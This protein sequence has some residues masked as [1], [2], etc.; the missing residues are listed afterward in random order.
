MVDSQGRTLLT[1]LL[2][3][4]PATGTA[5]VHIT[6]R[7]EETA[8]ADHL[9]RLDHGRLVTADQ[10]VVAYAGAANPLPSVIPQPAP[11]IL[12]M[13]DPRSTPIRRGTK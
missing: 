9:I 3:E 1:Q 6:H 8:G 7:I 10:A 11:M 5:V 12:P 2:V 4:L 13:P